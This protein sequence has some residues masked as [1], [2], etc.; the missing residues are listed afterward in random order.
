MSNK[1]RTDM[2][3]EEN[4]YIG[5][6]GKEDAIV[7]KVILIDKD[8]SKSG[9]PYFLWNLRIDNGPNQGQTIDARTT[10]IKGK[11]WLLKQGLDACGIQSN[12][13]GV[14]E[15]SLDDLKDK[16]ISINIRVFEDSYVTKMGEEKKITKREVNRFY[17]RTEEEIPL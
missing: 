7:V 3:D 2:S 13:D 9:N 12:K 6:G 1:L 16:L 5:E 14:Y 17:K 15:Y 4:P 10:A 8:K 11:R